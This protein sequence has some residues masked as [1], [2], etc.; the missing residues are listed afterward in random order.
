MKVNSRLKILISE[1]ELATG[2]RLGIRTVAEEAHA[3]VSTVQRLI[4]NTIRRVPLDDLAALCKYFECEVG[5]ILKYTPT[6]K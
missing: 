3:S 6:D 4:N 5:D 2:R 1:R